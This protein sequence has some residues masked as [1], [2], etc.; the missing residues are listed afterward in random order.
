MKNISS[1]FS[2]VAGSMCWASLSLAAP[3]YVA[4]EWGTF[5]SVQGADGVQMAWNPLSVSDLPAFVHDWPRSG[6][7]LQRELRKLNVGKSVSFTR[8][9]METPVIYFYADAPMTV[10]ARVQF[11]QGVMT[12][13]YPQAAF[14][15]QPKGTDAAGP[16]GLHWDNVQ[17]TP[18]SADDR[19][20]D[21][22]PAVPALPTSKSA[23]HYFAARETEADLVKVN[24]EIEK[25]LFYRGVGNFRAPLNVTQTGAGHRSLV[26]ANEGKEALR[27]LFIYQVGASGARFTHVQEVKS[28][29]QATVQLETAGDFIPL[30][31]ARTQLAARMEA[32][33]VSEGLYGAEAKAMVKTWD[34]SWFGENGLR[35]LYVLPGAWTDQTLPLQLEP[36]PADVVRVMVGRAELITP[37]MESDLHREIVR[38]GTGA[39]EDKTLAIE[40][41]RALGYG[42]FLEPTVRRLMTRRATDKIFTANSAALLEAASKPAS[43]GKRLAAR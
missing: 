6:P 3:N 4:H 33:L 21:A 41:V 32:A 24:G 27:H 36:K 38:Y 15:V 43:D 10:S 30:N 40:A 8:Q 13:W 39:S 11:P 19:K 17:L 1:V 22:Q 12:E 25:F 20:G 28:G 18:L 2:L 31:S 16:R 42:R 34:D 9:R 29:E 37:A 26:L 23:S 35:V 14:P 7:P 5:T